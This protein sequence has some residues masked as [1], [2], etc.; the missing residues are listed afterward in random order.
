MQ[1]PILITMGDPAGIGPEITLKSFLDESVQ[2]LPLIVLGDYGLLCEVKSFLNI[3]ELE[4]NKIEDITEARFEKNQVNILDFANVDREVFQFGNLSAMCGQS[5]FD[6]IKA[7]IDL[8]LAG[9][10]RAVTTAPINKAAL[11][12]A[13]HLYPGHTEI[14]AEGCDSSDFAMHLYDK[15][16]SVIHVST[17]TSLMDA[18]QNL[19]VAR[20]RKVIEIAE[21]NM[22]KILGRKPRIAVAGLNPHSGEGGIF[23]DQEERFIIPAIKSVKDTIDVVGPIPPDTVFYNGVNGEYDIVVA[24]YHDQGHIPFKMYAF[25]SGV[26]IS[27]GLEILR[28]SVDHGTAFNIAGTG[29]ANPNSMINA[30]LLADKLS[31]KKSALIGA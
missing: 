4:L 26:N 21:D 3:K 11:H 24:M 8:I 19:S 27:A 18:I 29:K 7:S 20:I 6:Y 14:Y 16:L 28:T 2:S 25:D 12:L 9:K 1:N 31:Q 22:T 13:G 30:I 17:H 23:G 5:A 15:K 10:A